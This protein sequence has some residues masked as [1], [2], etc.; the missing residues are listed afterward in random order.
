MGSDNGRTFT[1]SSG[2]TYSGRGGKLPGENG[3]NSSDFYSTVL[4]YLRYLTDSEISKLETTL[5]NDY[6]ETLRLSKDNVNQLD[7]T[8]WNDDV[9]VKL[10]SF[11]SDLNNKVLCDIETDV[12]SGNY[13]ALVNELKKLKAECEKYKSEENKSIQLIFSN[14]DDSKKYYAN[15]TAGLTGPGKREYNSYLSALNTKANNLELY[16]Q[17]IISIVT[18]I[19]TITFG[20]NYEESRVNE[21]EQEQLINLPEGMKVLDNKYYLFEAMNVKS[22]FFQDGFT[23]QIIMN[24]DNGNGIILTGFGQY[25]Y[26]I[27]DEMVFVLSIDESFFSLVDDN[28]NIS[29]DAEY[30]LSNNIKEINWANPNPELNNGIH[31]S[32]HGAE[33]NY[34]GLQTVINVNGVETSIPNLTGFTMID[35]VSTADSLI[36]NMKES[37]FIQ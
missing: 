22:D 15:D 36:N 12:S 8:V 13:R 25:V 27:V 35:L 9:S 33:M 7:Y 30:L 3:S 31:L 10:K 19:G 23:A 32:L 4:D 26:Q 29:E 37:G 2:T 24:K 6:L 16:K 1:S 17:N 14:P 20:G 28:G 5:K 34:P 21:N 11:T 18:N